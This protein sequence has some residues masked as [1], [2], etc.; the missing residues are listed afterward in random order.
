VPPDPKQPNLPPQFAALEKAIDTA[1]DRKLQPLVTQLGLMDEEV[2]RQGAMVAGVMGHLG[3]RAEQQ[4]GEDDPAEDESKVKQKDT[5]WCCVKCG[6]RLGFYD[7]AGD[8]LR[9]RHRDSVI[10]THIGIGGWV[11]VL[12]RQCSELNVLEYE[13][14]L[15]VEGLPV[16]GNRTILDVATLLHLLQEAQGSPDG[17]VTL[18]LVDMGEAPPAG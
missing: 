6:G 3:M 13:P 7:Q 5:I 10:Y 18:E 17:T 4:H 15:R 9:V 1:F 12:C 8:V 2:T 11:R 16:S 14:G